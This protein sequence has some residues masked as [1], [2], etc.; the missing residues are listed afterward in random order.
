[1][2]LADPG[3]IQRFRHGVVVV[4]PDG[5]VAGVRT[6]RGPDGHLLGI[7]ELDQGGLRPKVVVA[8]P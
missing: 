2:V 6:V 3:A 7:G 5:A 8:A 1:V 4:P